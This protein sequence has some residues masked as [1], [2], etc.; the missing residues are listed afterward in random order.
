MQVLISAE[1]EHEDSDGNKGLHRMQVDNHSLLIDLS[2]VRGALADRT[3]LRVDWGH[4]II[5]GAAGEGGTITL[6]DGST[7]PFAD[8]A[9]LKPYLDAFKARRAELDA[10]APA[11]EG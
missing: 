11:S 9:A 6:R 10:R 7:R 3:I 2:K 4:R 5:G 1:G 8:K